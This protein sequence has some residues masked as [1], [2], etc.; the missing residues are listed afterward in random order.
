MSETNSAGKTFFAGN[1][2]VFSGLPAPWAKL[3][4]GSGPL[5]AFADARAYMIDVAQRSL[6]FW[7]TLRRRGNEVSEAAARTAPSVLS[8]DSELVLDGHTLPRPVNY[9]LLHIKP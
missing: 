9:S 1:E 4:G 2:N 5:G 7:D 6:L 3:A 8:F